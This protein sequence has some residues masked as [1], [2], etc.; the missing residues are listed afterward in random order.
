[1]LSVF[2]LSAIGV[3]ACAGVVYV[4]YKKSKTV[5]SVGEKEAEVDS[6]GISDKPG[7]PGDNAE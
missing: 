2:V 5:E 3:C 4:V 1:M 7:K 6:I